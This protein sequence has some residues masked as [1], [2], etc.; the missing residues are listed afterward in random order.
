[1]AQTAQH[2]V[3][4][5]IKDL[6]DC[7]E[8]VRQMLLVALPSSFGPDLHPYQQETGAMI[9]KSL[10]QARVNAGE[11]RVVASQRVQEAQTV[12]EA[13]QADKQST[14]SDVE[15]AQSALSDKTVFLEA[16]RTSVTSEETLCEAA[17]DALSGV[18]AERQKQEAAKGAVESI[19]NGSL[20]M[21]LDG[22]WEDEEVRDMC[23]DGVC[24]YLN[25]EN[26]DAVL[27]AALPK[28]LARRPAE[29][30][31]FDKIAIEE[32]SRV[33][34]EKLAKCT[35]DLAQG[36][37]QFED[38]K[39][40]YRGAWAIL[41][42]AREKVESA[43]VECEKAEAALQEATVQNK[44]ALSKV[45]DQQKTLES[46]QSEVELAS[47]GVEQYEKAL[48]ALGQLA[49]GIQEEGEDKENVSLPCLA[50]KGDAM[51]LDHQQPAA[52][53]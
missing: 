18:E 16:A 27:L 11:A 52:V 22:G 42:L 32:A 53:A 35:A 23:I 3:A 48:A 43:A 20:R 45:Q 13:L 12:L 15:A 5:A 46:L 50:A 49:A 7:K 47:A 34:S 38:V 28:A 37:E 25:Q 8:S 40:E 10:E 6:H 9:R 30:G 44:I 24:S 26:A 2:E 33:M 19:Q 29:Y 17:K 4:A 31:V 39:A 41:D 21:L 14:E 36:E 51:E 1:M